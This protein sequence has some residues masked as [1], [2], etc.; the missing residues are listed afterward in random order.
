MPNHRIGLT[1]AERQHEL[2]M[3]R[4]MAGEL[5]GRVLA[6]YSDIPGLAKAHEKEV[7]KS[8][9]LE[10]IPLQVD[11]DGNAS[12]AAVEEANE[13]QIELDIVRGQ[14]IGLA[15]SGIYHLWEQ[16][17]KK[18]LLDRREKFGLAPKQ[19][20][21]VRGGK[22]TDLEAIIVACGWNLKTEPFYGRLNELRLIA[23]TVKHGDGASCNEL[24]QLRKGLFL[25]QDFLAP[26]L[27]EHLSRAERLFLWD[28]TFD[29]YSQAVDGFWANF[30]RQ[31]P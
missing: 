15:I 24:Y 25:P 27:D 11:E 2:W 4:L 17:I 12:D 10:G 8:L 14:I 16:R 20:K 23:N 21:E 28:T 19:I 7:R 30:P 9:G 13:Y 5:R 3:H 6:A 29:E 31:M 26:F 18:C 22:F 1:E